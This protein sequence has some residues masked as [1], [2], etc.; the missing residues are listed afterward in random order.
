MY[1]LLSARISSG[2]WSGSGVDSDD[3]GHDL[4]VTGFGGLVHLEDFGMMPGHEVLGR[5]VPP[6]S[7][8]GQPGLWGRVKAGVGGRII[9][10]RIYSNQGSCG[11][12]PAPW[13]GVWLKGL[14]FGHR[15]SG[16]QAGEGVQVEVRKSIFGVLV[17]Y[18]DLCLFQHREQEGA[19]CQ[20]L[21]PNDVSSWE[22][23]WEWWGRYGLGESDGS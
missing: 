16:Q 18:E 9:A 11:R 12:L 17:S 8:H 5:E 13:S 1:L 2:L 19:P 15:C 6:H 3:G 10:V 4:W 21:S 23:T 14:G 7:P 22:G 20:R